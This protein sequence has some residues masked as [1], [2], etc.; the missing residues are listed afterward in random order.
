MACVSNHVLIG[1]AGSGQIAVYDVDG[2]RF[3]GL[4]RD[5][6]G[7][8]IQDDRLWALRFGNDHGGRIQ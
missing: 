6:N 4:H 1:K 3:D 5:A 7:H 2:A 8:A